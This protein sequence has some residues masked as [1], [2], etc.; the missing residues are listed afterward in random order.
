MKVNDSYITPLIQSNAMEPEKASLQK[1]IP[2]KRV[3]NSNEAAPAKKTRL[4]NEEQA[5]NII[6]K[7]FRKM[8]SDKS[9]SHMFSEGEIWKKDINNPE[10]FV[11]MQKISSKNISMLSKELAPLSEKEIIFLTEF[12]D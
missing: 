11:T 9:Y 3:V 5:S 6:T 2:A 1:C 7:N 12:L 8:I 4:L 10:G